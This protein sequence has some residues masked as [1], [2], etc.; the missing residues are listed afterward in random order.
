MKLAVEHIHRTIRETEA[1][2]AAESEAYEAQRRQVES[3]GAVVAG[4]KALL[5]DLRA[6]QVRLQGAQLAAVETPVETKKKRA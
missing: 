3:R 1:K 4:L 6:A 2:I 5:E